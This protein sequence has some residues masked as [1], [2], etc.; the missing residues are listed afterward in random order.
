[1]ITLRKSFV[2][3]YVKQLS[4]YMYI[5]YT[6]MNQSLLYKETLDYEIKR[7]EQNIIFKYLIL[8]KNKR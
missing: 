2:Y 5:L 1:M 6:Y 8:S 4:L 3:T 7:R